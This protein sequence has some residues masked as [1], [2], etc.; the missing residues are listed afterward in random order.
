MPELGMRSLSPSL[1]PG[2]RIQVISHYPDDEWLMAYDAHECPLGSKH[3]IIMDVSQLELTFDSSYSRQLFM[4]LMV[5]DFRPKWQC[6]INVYI[7]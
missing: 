1:S 7:L 2:D 5:Y 6:T 4:V 3:L